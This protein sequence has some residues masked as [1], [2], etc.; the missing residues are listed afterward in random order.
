[1]R[2]LHREASTG[3]DDESPSDTTYC[4]C[5]SSSCL[6]PLFNSP[7]DSSPGF[8]SHT[9]STPAT[10]ASTVASD[11]QSLVSD[12][13]GKVRTMIVGSTQV[14]NEDLCTMQ[15]PVGEHFSGCHEDI[16]LGLFSAETTHDCLMAP[17][18]P[19]ICHNGAH[20]VDS[21]EASAGFDEHGDWYNTW[22]EH[23]HGSVV[24][25]SPLHHATA[26]MT[27]LSLTTA[28]PTTTASEF[29]AAKH[30][31]RSSMSYCETSPYVAELMT[32]QTHAHFE[33]LMDPAL[34][35]ASF[36]DTTLEQGQ[37]G[38]AASPFLHQGMLFP[39][40]EI[41]GSNVGAE[42]R[43]KTRD[44]STPSPKS[45]PTSPGTMYDV[46]MADMPLRGPRTRAQRRALT[47][48]TEPERQKRRQTTT[49][50]IRCEDCKKYFKKASNLHTHRRT[51]LPERRKEHKC[52]DPGC[53][54]AFDRMADLNRHARVS[55]RV[56]SVHQ[57]ASNADLNVDSYWRDAIPMHLLR[58][59]L[60]A[61]RYSTK[62]S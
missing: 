42:E 16:G 60:Q 10:P 38:L 46:D 37:G 28:T 36:H 47:T 6:C 3:V 54:R 17:F 55:H 20:I 50:P 33:D 29:S 30:S 2:L 18:S 51:H 58:P 15:S 26:Y 27:P 56:Q 25:T 32:N 40:Q 1:M 53:S 22:T 21:M 31:A 19:Q 24:S 9:S 13:L 14:S 4:N 5:S 45:E 7:R 43:F 41:L 57:N 35:S 52:H 12:Q 23:P 59:A 61:H 8:C 39:P 49:G 34:A 44:S 48:Q 11:P 62:V